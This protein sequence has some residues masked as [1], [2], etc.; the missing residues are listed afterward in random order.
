MSIVMG[1]SSIGRITGFAMA[2]SDDEAP[3]PSVEVLEGADILPKEVK[4]RVRLITCF[5]G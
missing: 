2:A 3:A 1:S 5:T 4:K